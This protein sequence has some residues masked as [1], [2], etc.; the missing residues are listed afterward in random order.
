[1]GRE[2]GRLGIRAPRVGTISLAAFIAAL[3][4]KLFPF[5]LLS[6][7]LWCP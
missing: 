4:A 2:V 7:P 6:T 5:V 3:S 1:M